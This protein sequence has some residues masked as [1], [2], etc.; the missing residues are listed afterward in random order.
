KILTKHFNKWVSS[1]AA[2][3]NLQ[4]WM[5]AAD[6]TLR[7]SDFAGEECYPGIDLASKLDLNAVVPVFRREID[8]LSHYYCVSPMF[9]VPE[10]TV[11]A[12]DPALK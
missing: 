1:K 11:Y 12:T 10:D 8:G 9:W 4:K 5:T 6:K 7:L 3:Y 2:Y